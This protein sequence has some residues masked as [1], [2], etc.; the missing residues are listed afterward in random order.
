MGEKYEDIQGLGF[1]MTK[2]IDTSI[3]E[4]NI[5]VTVTVGQF[6]TIV[7]KGFRTLRSYK[8]DDVADVMA[9]TEETFR[10]GGKAVAGAVI[11]GL[12][13]GGIGFLAGAAIGGR[14][15]KEGMYAIA[16]KDGNHVVIETSDKKL[17]AK[18]QPIILRKNLNLPAP[19][20]ALSEPKAVSDDRHVIRDD[21]PF[22]TTQEALRLLSSGRTPDQ[23]S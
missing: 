6:L 4:G 22:D 9:V 12:L 13:T 14:R 3:T 21:R 7:T 11:G 8:D 18:L 16:F 23:Q 17:I 1:T 15:R 5:S 20:P 2:I 10:H 19:Q